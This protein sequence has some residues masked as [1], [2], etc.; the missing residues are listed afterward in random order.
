MAFDYVNEYRITNNLDALR[1]SNNAF[2]VSGEMSNLK[3]GNSGYFSRTQDRGKYVLENL[4]V[5][6]VTSTYVG[7]YEI[8]GLGISE[9]KR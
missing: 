4:N 5:E 2:I 7:I 3:Q 1:F 8:E 6:N 9:F